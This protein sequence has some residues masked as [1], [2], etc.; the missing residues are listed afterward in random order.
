MGGLSHP[1][2]GDIDLSIISVD[3]DVI[4]LGKGLLKVCFDDPRPNSKMAKLQYT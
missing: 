4:L 3:C 1:P 2:K